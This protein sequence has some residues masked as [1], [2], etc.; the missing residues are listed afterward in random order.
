M[1]YPS[2]KHIKCNITREL[3]ADWNYLEFDNGGARIYYKADN[4][5]GYGF[6]FYAVEQIGYC[7]LPENTG[8]KWHK[9]NCNVECIF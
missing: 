6:K 4:E 3:I 1:E 7:I 9:D 2:L 8:D 5:K